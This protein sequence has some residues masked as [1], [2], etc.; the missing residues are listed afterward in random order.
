MASQETVLRGICGALD[1]YLS[2]ARLS[3]L[4]LRE[5]HSLNALEKWMRG[6]QLMDQW[7]PMADSRAETM[8]LAKADPEDADAF[9]TALRAADFKSTRG[10]FSFGP[11]QHPVQDWYAVEVVKGADGKPTTVTKEKIIENYGDIYAADCKM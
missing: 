8:F 7:D 6:Q 5:P 3:Q 4:R 1:V 2:Q 11:N 9:R 10:N